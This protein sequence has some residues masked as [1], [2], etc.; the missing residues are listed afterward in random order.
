MWRW[1]WL[2]H[3]SPWGRCRR[4]SCGHG[5]GWRLCGR[6]Y[7]YQRGCGIRSGRGRR[8]GRW[9]RYRSCC[10]IRR[11]CWLRSGRRIGCWRR[12][13][14]GRRVGC[15][16]RRRRVGRIGRRRGFR[17]VQLDCGRLVADNRGLL[18]RESREHSRWSRGRRLGPTAVIAAGCQGQ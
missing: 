17:R 10:W 2:S 5:G 4:Y 7:G 14:S 13:W 11:G 16:S 18:S 9:R 6:W 8:V 12:H 3:R 1:P 15:R